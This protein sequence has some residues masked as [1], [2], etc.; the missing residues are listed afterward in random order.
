MCQKPGKTLIPIDK[1]QV[2]FVDVVKC[3]NEVC[4]QT[5]LAPPAAWNVHRP[6]EW[7][8]GPVLR[9]KFDITDWPTD[10]PPAYPGPTVAGGWACGWHDRPPRSAQGTRV[11]DRE[12]DWNS[13]PVKGNFDEFHNQWLTHWHSYQIADL[14]NRRNITGVNHQPPEIAFC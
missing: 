12:A 13:A 4:W 14:F 6:S 3:V 7:I 9:G 1:L 10:R 2:Y 11:L 8:C 5:H